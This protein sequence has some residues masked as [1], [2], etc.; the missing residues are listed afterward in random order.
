MKL[1][2]VARSYGAE[3]LH[4]T[5]V[6]EHNFHTAGAQT[7]QFTAKAELV[8]AIRETGREPV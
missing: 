5:I 6:E 3:D 8:K 1:A 7:P 4:E 2:Q